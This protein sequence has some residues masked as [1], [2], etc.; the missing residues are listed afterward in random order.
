MATTGIVFCI[1]TNLERD[2]HYESAELRNDLIKRVKEA[3]EATERRDH[4]EFAQ[5]SGIIESVRTEEIEMD[6]L[7]SATGKVNAK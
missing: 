6:E 5:T 3:M 7:G 4:T 1:P 2:I